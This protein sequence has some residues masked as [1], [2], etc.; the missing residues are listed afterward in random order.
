PHAVTAR[1]SRGRPPAVTGARG[2]PADGPH[3]RSWDAGGR[4]PHGDPA[5]GTSAGAQTPTLKRAKEVTSVP[6][7]LATWATDLLASL[8][9]GWSSSTFSLKNPLTRPS[10][11]LGS[12][13][14]GLPSSR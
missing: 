3:L 10:M 12:A 6:A 8:A 7:S 14:S 4:A 1:D 2:T 9:N 5:S 13:C 11:I